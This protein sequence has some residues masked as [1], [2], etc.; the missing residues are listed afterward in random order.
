VEIYGRNKNYCRCLKNSS[1]ILSSAILNG[2]SCTPIDFNEQA[3]HIR[4][5]QTNLTVSGKLLKNLAV[6]PSPAGMSLTSIAGRE[7]R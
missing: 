6:F 3:N 1:L 4:G 2:I 5:P 7:N